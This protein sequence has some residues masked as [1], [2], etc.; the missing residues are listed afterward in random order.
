M[1]E[2]REAIYD[3]LAA[4]A[5]IRTLT[6]W[7][8]SDDRIYY[9]WP[10]ERVVVDATAPAYL[11]YSLSKPVGIPMAMYVEAAQVEDIIVE[12]D[13]WA[14]KVDGRD[15]LAE[16]ITAIFKDYAFTTTSYRVM[17]TRKEAEEDVGEIQEGTGQLD[18]Y[19]KYIRLR[20]GSIYKLESP[21]Y[22]G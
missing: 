19:R 7:T 10:Q 15:D 9:G 20:M 1:K 16:R 14:F 11:T 12:I 5:S 4:D 13:I 17:T 2:I 8:A 18:L 3:R 21:Y 22:G 6:G